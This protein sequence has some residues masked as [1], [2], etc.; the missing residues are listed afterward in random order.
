[1]SEADG[2]AKVV[3]FGAAA[4]R[5]GVREEKVPVRPDETLGDLWETLSERHPE[6][7]PLRATLVF[8]VNNEYAG[9]EAPVRDGDEVAVLPP[10]SGG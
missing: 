2:A 10:V 5:A 1:M 6:L 3:F 9:P 4:D 7:L 8:A